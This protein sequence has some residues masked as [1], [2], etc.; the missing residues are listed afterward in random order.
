MSY[1][2]TCNTLVPKCLTGLQR[3]LNALLGFLFTCE[4]D[5]GLALQ[6]EQIL[7]TDQS[8]GVDLSA[9]EHVSYLAGDLHFVIGDELATPHDVDSHLQGCQ[10]AFSGRW[11]IGTHTQRAIAFVHQFESALVGV[12]QHALAVH[13]DV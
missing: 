3:E 12:A 10:D 5:E 11:D 13:A 4:R 6:V 9:A 8:A 7:L 1:T 2:V